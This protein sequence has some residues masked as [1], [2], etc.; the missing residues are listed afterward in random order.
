MEGVSLLE[1]F[2]EVRCGQS[3]HISLLAVAP[4]ALLFFTIGV[5]LFTILFYRRW[6]VGK[7]ASVYLFRCSFK[8]NVW[9][10]Y[11]FP[12]YWKLTGN[13]P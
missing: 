1:F 11:L 3:A 7:V 13:F 4:I 9:S 6:V 12:V 5:P 2:P 8:T 10:P